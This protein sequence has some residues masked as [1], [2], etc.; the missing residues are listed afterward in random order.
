MKLRSS[1]ILFLLHKALA[2]PFVF[3]NSGHAP[4]EKPGVPR[5]SPEFW[6]KLFICMGLVLAGGVFAGYVIHAMWFRI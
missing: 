2:S 3:T 1:T 4:T 5:D 6:Y